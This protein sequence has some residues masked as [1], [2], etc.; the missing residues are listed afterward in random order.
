[1]T[2]GYVSARIIVRYYNLWKEFSIKALDPLD[3]R[4]DQRK[5]SSLTALT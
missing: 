5:E 4:S 1:M 2:E 3:A